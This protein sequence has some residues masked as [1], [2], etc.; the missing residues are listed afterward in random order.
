MQEILGRD[1]FPSLTRKRF[2]SS[3]RNGNIFFELCR[4]DGPATDYYAKAL[5]LRT[6]GARV[7]WRAWKGTQNQEQG[8][9]SWQD[10]FRTGITQSRRR[11]RSRIR[12]RRSSF[13]NGPSAPK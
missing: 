2:I 3:F 12:R 13:T 4:F 9:V 11:L 10:P 1:S 8:D 6:R 5:S 7:I